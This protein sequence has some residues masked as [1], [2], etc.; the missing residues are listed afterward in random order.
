MVLCL[1]LSAALSSPVLCSAILV[2]QN[3]KLHFLKEIFQAL[4]VI[5]L[6]AP[7]GISRQW[8]GAVIWLTLFPIP[9]GSLLSFV[10]W[11]CHENHHFMYFVWYFSCFKQEDKFEFLYSILVRNWIPNWAQN[12]GTLISLHFNEQKNKSIWCLILIVRDFHFL[13]F[14]QPYL[15]FRL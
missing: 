7:S 9:Q 2:S 1:C 12:H 5:H 4:A 10:A 13:V 3:S 15:L 14:Q 11:Q 8:V 6:L